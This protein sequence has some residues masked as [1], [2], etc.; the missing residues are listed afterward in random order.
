[1]MAMLRATSL[2]LEGID[3]SVYYAYICVTKI[4]KLEVCRMYLCVS[5]PWQLSIGDASHQRIYIY[6]VLYFQSLQ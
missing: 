2:N 5:F 4:L 6:A 1:M 3:T